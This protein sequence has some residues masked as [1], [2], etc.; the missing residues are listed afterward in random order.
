MRKQSN[1]TCDGRLEMTKW[2]L[3]NGVIDPQKWGQTRNM[4]GALLLNPQIPVNSATA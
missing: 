4:T 1:A 3:E 2:L